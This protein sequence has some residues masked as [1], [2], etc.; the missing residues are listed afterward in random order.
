M[1]DERR[2]VVLA[3]RNPDK[4]AELRELCADLPFALRAA[5]DYPGLPEVIEDGTTLPGNAARKAIV[6]AAYTGE[7]AV[8]DDT[9]LRVH[10]L[11]DLPD[12]FAARFAGPGADY[13]ANRDLLLELLRDVPDDRRQAWFQTAVAWVDPRPD[14]A[15]AAQPVPPLV[16]RRW[17]WNPYHRPVHVPPEREPAFW[18]ALADRGAVWREYVARRRLPSTAPGVDQAR[19]DR[20]LDE[21]TAGLVDGGPPAGAPAGAV[22]LPD[23]RLWTVTGPDAEEDDLPTHVSPSGLPAD[24]PGR[25]TAARVWCAWSAEGRVLG[26]I[27]REPL[28][29]GGFG[30]DPVFRPAGSPLTLA[31]MTPAEKHAVSHRGRALRRLLDAVRE[32]YA[33]AV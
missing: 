10:A 25:E 21:L 12:V 17:L 11:R 26:E 27:T 24:A 31:E 7:I 2:I 20:I 30:Y 15:W 9:A 22:R 18:N 6:T 8:A 5:G 29:A 23:T 32:V 1:S 33:V 3:S 19:L 4:L 14:P 28:G 16:Q 13:A